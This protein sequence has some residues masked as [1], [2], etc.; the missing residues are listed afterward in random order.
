V[1][2]ADRKTSSGIPETVEPLGSRGADSVEF[3]IGDSVLVLSRDGTIVKLQFPP[4]GITDDQATK[5]TGAPVESLWPGELAALLHSNVKRTLRNRQAQSA[6][7]ED[8]RN[9][10][11]YEFI[12]V[13]QGP[14]RV[15]VVVR[16]ISERKSAISEMQQLAYVDSVTGLPNQKY[17]IRELSRIVDGLRLK[18][19]RAAVICFDIDRTDFDNIASGKIKQDAALKELATRLTGGLR[20]VNQPDTPD[21][22]RY[23][24]AVRIDF[25]QFA[26]VLP[27]IE[28]GSDAA[29]VT[30]RLSES[31][32]QQIE[33]GTSSVGVTVNAGIALF[34]Q[35]GADA[36]TLLGSAH[37]AMEDAKSSQTMQPRFHSGTV[38]VRALQRQDMVLELQSALDR[39]EFHLEYLPI[40]E[41][42]TRNVRTAEALL[43]W[44]QEVFSSR[45]I[46]QVIS[47]AEHT[48]LIVPI[49][50]WVLRHSC[51][52]L[53]AWHA[54]GN[55]GLRLAVNLSAQEFSRADLATR[56]ADIL[57]TS[58]IE[59]RY[60]DLEITEHILFR[61]AL[62]DF[63]MCRA[64]KE[65]GVGVVVDDYGTGACSLAH[66]AGSPV[67]T[68][69]ID[70]GFV[71]HS[72]T[73]P[74]DRA[75]CAAAAAMAHELSLKVVAESVETEEQAMIMQELGCDFLQ[76]FLFLRP[77]LASEFT[78]YLAST[79]TDA[80]V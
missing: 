59:P 14:D 75:A 5:L 47:L 18:G 44:P 32:Q 60:I 62:R 13:A 15:L 4:D 29:A 61:D 54:S 57:S 25:C 77:S 22:E 8:S 80:I 35:D 49:G 76:G 9:G 16:N 46:Q 26:V 73:N 70:G 71:T 6:E 50:E 63:S 7:F 38:K 1:V 20:G 24:I 65:L 56:V 28:D 79:S 42:G 45:P 17:L 3:M 40:V 67:D 39:E 12:F 27:I 37:A 19:G 66:L 43:R 33:I 53:H 21:E 31:L 69:K 36:M 64:L 68:V 51:E 11:H 2:E 78:E 72:E 52:Q 55:S 74:S 23:S 10:Q 48:G 34:P 58:S 41:A 30:S